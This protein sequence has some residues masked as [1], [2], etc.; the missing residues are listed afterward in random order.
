METERICSKC[1]YH[2]KHLRPKLIFV[3]VLDNVELVQCPKCHHIDAVDEEFR[4][5]TPLIQ[6]VEAYFRG[7]P[8]V[9]RSSENNLL[10]GEETLK[11]IAG[12]DLPL[13]CFLVENVP[14]DKY[15]ASEWPEILE[16]LRQTYM[17]GEMARAVRPVK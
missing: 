6:A 11:T 5:Q 10:H 8:V 1:G 4:W 7:Q 15:D 9:V 3:G 17:E 12:L 16:R 14:Q 2:G 13:N